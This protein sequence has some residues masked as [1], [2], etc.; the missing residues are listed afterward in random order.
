MPTIEVVR[1]YLEMTSPSDLVGDDT[2]PPGTRLERVE[3]CTPAFHRFLY[4]E[5]GRQCHW[6]D[7]LSWSDEQF[8]AYLDGGVNV[9][10]LYHGGAPAGYFDLRPECDGS[11]EIN[12]FGLLPQ[13]IGRG[14]GRYLLSMAVREAWATGTER[15]WLHTCTL[16][17]PS[18]LPNYLK[19]GFR[20]VGEERY[21]ANVP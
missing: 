17:H 3:R 9:W 19:R 5:V 15:V 13:A 18:A 11:V 4:A 10:V 20:A 7:R 8:Q 14:F 12:Y 2:P 1:T 21:T 6:Q 16:D